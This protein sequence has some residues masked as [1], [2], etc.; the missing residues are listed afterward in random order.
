MIAIVN[1][2][3]TRADQEPDGWH[4]YEVRIEREVICAFRHCRSDG[5]ARCL[6]LAAEAVKKEGSGI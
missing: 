3:P 4:Y 6:E 5:L 2:G 1:M